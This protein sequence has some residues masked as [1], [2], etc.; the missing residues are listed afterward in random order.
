MKNN[1]GMTL[2]ELLVTFSLL[3][4]I[5]VGLYNLILEV[6]FEIDNKQ[7]VKDTI[8]Y[9]SLINNDIHYNLLIDKPFA[10]VMKNKDNWECYPKNTDICNVGSTKIAVNYIKSG[11]V[12]D[13]VNNIYDDI[14]GVI[15]KEI[16]PCAVYYY[17]GSDNKIATKVIALSKYSEDDNIT[18]LANSLKTKGILY[19]SFDIRDSNTNNK[20]IFEPV[21]NNEYIEIRDTDAFV[22]ENGV[23][24]TT[25]KTNK[26]KIEVVNDVLIINYG[27]Y[28]ID[29]DQNYGFKIAY[30]FPSKVAS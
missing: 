13:G 10:I 17:I 30:P 28:V 5:V 15:C 1:K 6:K 8:E 14:N 16:Y 22:G 20:S 26:P 9:S 3:L 18:G 19:G 7:I 4:I 27:L 24:D 29:D 2:V 25:I 23:V 11:S 12:I 21:P